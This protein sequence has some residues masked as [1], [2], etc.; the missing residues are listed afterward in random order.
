MTAVNWHNKLYDPRA[1]DEHHKGMS[2][3]DIDFTQHERSSAFATVCS[4]TNDAKIKISDRK[5][6]Q[7]N[8]Y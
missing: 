1:S 7:R 2:W 6:N 5:K 8:C 4:L 3:K